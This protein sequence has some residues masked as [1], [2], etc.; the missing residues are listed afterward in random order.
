MFD[1]D[2]FSGSGVS[3]DD[4]CFA[5]VYVEREALEDFLRAERLVE[6]TRLDHDR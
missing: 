5:F 4:H 6:S 2:G 1:G 3:D